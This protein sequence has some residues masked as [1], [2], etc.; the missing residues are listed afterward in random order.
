MSTSNQSKPNSVLIAVRDNLIS[1]P[2]P[3]LQTDCEIVWCRLDIVGHKAIYLT[4][5]YNP[6]TL[7]EEG[8]IQ[9]I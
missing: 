9:L 6:K 8:Y 2:I 7:N 4:L 5:Y 1:S 3:E